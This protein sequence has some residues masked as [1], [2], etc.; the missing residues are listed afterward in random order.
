[1]AKILLVEDNEEN[2]SAIK[3]ILESDRHAL[4]CASS[5]DEGWGFIKTYKYD[6]MIFDWEMPGMSGVEL[7][8][9]YRLEGGSC[10]V[11][12]L[13]GRDATPDKITGL[14]A[15]ADNYLTKPF[16]G[17][18]LLSLVRATLRRAP[19]ENPKDIPFADL[20]L[21]PLSSS[22]VCSEKE[23]ALSA[24][25]IAVLSLLVQNPDRIVSQ[26]EMKIAGWSDGGEPSAGAMRVFLSSLRE[27]LNSI[28]SNIQILSIKGYGYQ[29]KAKN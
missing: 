27:K 6:L 24:K 7:L 22:V 3:T 12:M 16:E 29:I 25:E 10:S 20:V 26:D 9:K 8:N 13:T 14:N 15:G 5:A 4:D 11:I 17:D 1:M 2:R 21:R 23:I 18:V 19:L 28:G